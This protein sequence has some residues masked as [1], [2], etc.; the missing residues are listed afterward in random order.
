MNFYRDLAIRWKLV[1]IILLTT[2][3]ALVLACISFIAFDWISSKERMVSNI[4]AL[5]G[6]VADN[7]ISALS[8]LDADAAEETL[9]TLRVERHLVSACIY[10]A[11][12]QVFATYHRDGADF[13]PPA[14]ETASYRFGDNALIVFHPIML[15]DEVLGTVYIQADLQELNERRNRYLSIAGLLISGSIVVALLVAAHA[16]SANVPFQYGSAVV[17]GE[18]LREAH[19]AGPARSDVDTN[20]IR[21]VEA[22]PSDPSLARTAA[23]M[24][25]PAA[26]PRPDPCRCS[27]RTSQPRGRGGAR[28]RPSRS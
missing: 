11:D 17:M 23:G 8:F 3:V 15:N 27:A 20:P 10:Q 1:S 18:A 5:A 22:G 6:V 14:P 25:T 7:S 26:A 2:I 28:A 13:D 24:P 21:A 16:L 19:A 12:G 4:Q 9:L